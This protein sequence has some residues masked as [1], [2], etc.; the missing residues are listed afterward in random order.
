MTVI[1]NKIRVLFSLFLKNVHRFV[2]M[3]I[4]AYIC[5]LAESLW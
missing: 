5:K 4:V 2:N 1:I 3:W